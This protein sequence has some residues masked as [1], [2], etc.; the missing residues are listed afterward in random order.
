MGGE[1]VG[2]G[3]FFQVGVGI[4]LESMV[5]ANFLDFIL[6][7]WMI[8]GWYLV[9]KSPHGDGK[10]QFLI[11]NTTVIVFIQKFDHCIAVIL[12]KSTIIQ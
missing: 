3:W 9:F 11:E 2:G 10:I 1:L 4:P 6:V 12:E 5:F 7:I 8:N